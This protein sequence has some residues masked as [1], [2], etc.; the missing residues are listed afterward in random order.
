MAIKGLYP[1]AEKWSRHGAVWIYSDPHFGDSDQKYMD[2]NWPSDE[3][4]IKRINSKVGK[5]DTLIILGDCG[6]PAMCAQLRGYKVL[7]MGNHDAG[8][9]N[10]E[11]HKTHQYY[12][13]RTWAKDEAL[14]HFKFHHPFLYNIT[15]E[16]EV[17]N[18]CG[19]DQWYV[20]GD[21][22]L[23][24]EIYEGPLMISEKLILSHEPLDIDWAFNIHGHNHNPQGKSD[25]H[26]L[27]VCSNVINYTPV[28]FNQLVKNGLTSKVL[29]IHRETIAVATKNKK[30]RELKNNG[31]VLL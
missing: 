18:V 12:P 29:T 27:N 15:I 31:M 22:R 14:F 11:R 1:F 30:K 23:F 28:N 24:D 26:H 21:N 9:T 3:E 25:N 8:R 10:Y 5:K 16:V 4:Q 7:V 20:T 13:I 6:D 19:D 17:D 2:I